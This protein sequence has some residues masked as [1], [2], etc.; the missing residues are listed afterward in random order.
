M[1]SKISAYQVKDRQTVHTTNR[2]CELCK[3][4]VKKD[5][6]SGNVNKVFCLGSGFI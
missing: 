4:N 5:K 1:T 6:L 2:V 3:V